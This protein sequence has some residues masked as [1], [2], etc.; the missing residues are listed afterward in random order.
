VAGCNSPCPRGNP[1]AA[2]CNTP[3]PRGN[4]RAAWCNSP[5]PRG[6]RRRTRCQPRSSAGGTQGALCRTAYF[7]MRSQVARWSPLPFG[8][9]ARAARWPTAISTGGMSSVAV[10]TLARYGRRAFGG[11]LILFEN[12]AGTAGGGAPVGCRSRF[13]APIL[14]LAPS[15]LPSGTRTRFAPIHFAAFQRGACVAQQLVAREVRVS[16]RASSSAS[17]ARGG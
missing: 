6:N 8:V 4:P 14:G 17:G 10:R 12:R 7:A 1:R 9:S 15:T 11:V 2:W 13:C 16:V 5:C 3:C